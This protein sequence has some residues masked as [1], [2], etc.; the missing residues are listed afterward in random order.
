MDHALTIACIDYWSCFS[1]PLAMILG[2]GRNSHTSPICWR[3]FGKAPFLH[4]AITINRTREA[5]WRIIPH[6]CTNCS[7]YSYIPLLTLLQFVFLKKEVL[8]FF[9]RLS[10][11]ALTA[12][13]IK[14]FELYLYDRY[15]S[16][17]RVEGELLAPG[18]S[19]LLSSASVRLLKEF[20]L[21][22][23]IVRIW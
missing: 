3:S 2:R 11:K 7:G 16:P 19:C 17:Y 15:E 9:F 21:R 20:G 6:Y 8:G 23:G 22:Y 18:L 12:I 14:W 4:L 1:P 10:L 13:K 5:F